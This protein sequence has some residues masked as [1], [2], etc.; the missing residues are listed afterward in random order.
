MPRQ[1]VYAIYGLCER[2]GYIVLWRS[3]VIGGT[4]TLDKAIRLLNLDPFR[5]EDQ[6]RPDYYNRSV[7]KFYQH[8]EKPNKKNKMKLYMTQKGNDVIVLEVRISAYTWKWRSGKV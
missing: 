4:T 3:C 6:T 8:V 1:G 2:Y 7:F 5:N